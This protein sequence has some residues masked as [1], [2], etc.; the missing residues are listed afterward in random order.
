M[1]NCQKCSIPIEGKFDFCDPCFVNYKSKEIVDYQDISNIDTPK[2][3]RRKIH[4][5]DV[6]SN[7]IKCNK[8]WEVIRSKNVHNMQRCKC[9]SVAVD[10][11]SWYLK[12]SGN[13]EDYEELFINYNNL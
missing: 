1:K 8:C 3:V 10:W 6:R 11:G 5:G 13:L 12:R 2:D 7:E 4:I 9:W